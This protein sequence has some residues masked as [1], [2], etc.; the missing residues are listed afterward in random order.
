[1]ICLKNDLKEVKEYYNEMYFNEE[2]ANQIKEG[3]HQQIHRKRR[4]S[5]GKKFVYVCSAFVAAFALFIG[6]AFL[7]P[8]VAKVAA[9]VPFLN[10]IFE[11]KPISEVIAETLTEKGYPFDGVGTQYTPKKVFSVGLRGSKEYIDRVRPDVKKLVKDLLLARDFDAYEVKVYSSEGKVTE[12]TPEEMKADKKFEKVVGIVNGVLKKY[13]YTEG[14]PI[15]FQAV[16]QTVD[17]SLPNTESEIDEIKQQVQSQLNAKNLGSFTLKV[18]VY[19]A[20]KKERERRWSPII[21]TIAEGTFG[22][23]KYKVTELG[24]T[25]KSA[26][27]MMIMLKTSVSS[28]D[29]D[30]QEVV[31]DI[32]D[33]IQE[34]LTS[35]KTRE[36]IKDDA[37]KVIITSKDKK[38]TVITSK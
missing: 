20:K 24:Y 27:Y 8:A 33:T 13:G 2:I 22:A 9:K 28:S 6:L 30:Y 15:G 12:P 35:K 38:E 29:S 25:N 26:E 23:K 17:F 14:I 7:S 18:N 34:F 3:V 19:N 5:I 4:S 32:K 36:I 16:N 37:Y 11:S 1:M 10:M 31:D 21:S